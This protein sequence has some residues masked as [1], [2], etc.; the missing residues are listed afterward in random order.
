VRIR[1]PHLSA[2][3]VSVALGLGILPGSIAYAQ[4]ALPTAS[5]AQGQ[6]LLAAD[7]LIY[8]FD[9][10][11]VTAV[12]GVQIK[13]NGYDLVAQK[14][15]FNRKT[16]RLL[17]NGNV[18]LT[19]PDGTKLYADEIDV[20]DNLADGFINALRV[21][22]TD[23]TRFAAVR[24]TRENG[25]IATF[26]RGVYTACEPCLDKPEKPPT[27]QVKAETIIWNQ[28]R[29]T[30]R[31]QGARFELF[32]FSLA[33]LPS[34]EI[35]DHTVKRKS[36]FLMPTVGY[37]DRLGAS[38]SIPYFWALAPNM[39]F[40][41][42]ARPMS[43]Q[44]LFASGKFAHQL[45]SGSYTVTIAGTSQLDPNAFGAGTVN[46][47]QN[48]RFLV[49]TK[50]AFKINPRW[51][52]GWDVVAQTDKNFGY[53]YK[54]PGYDAYTRASEIYLTGL[55][56]RNYFDLRASRFEVQEDV[57]SG[58][59]EKQAT[60]LPSF[61]YRKTF[62]EAVL[63]GELTLRM[64]ARNIDRDV[65]DTAFVGLTP[66]PTFTPADNDSWRGIAGSNGRVTASADWQSTFIA[67]GGLSITPIAALRADG[68]YSDFDDPTIGNEAASRGLIAETRDTLFRGLV[69]AGLDIKY[70][71]LFTAP[72]STH[73]LEPRVQLLARN[74]VEGQERLGSANEDAQSLVF[75]A[76]NLFDR[77]K[78]SGLD[79]IEGG[80]RANVGL[81]Y[82]GTFDNGVRADASFGQSFNVAGDN[83][84]AAPDLVFAGA[85]SG[86]ETKASDYVASA[87]LAYNEFAV[88]G[89]ARFD[90]KTFELRRA[91]VQASSRFEDLSLS[92]R[93]TYIQAQPQYGFSNDRQE[94]KGA[95][96]LK[97]AE[98]WTASANAVFNIEAKK[99]SSFG[100]G[101]RYDDECFTYGMAYSESRDVV[102]NVKKRTVGFNISLRTLGEISN[103]LKLN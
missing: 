95:A 85:F 52:F 84:F 89:G 39:D 28:Q 15:K 92:A 6:M 5:T 63:G 61:D 96:S 35:A 77:D 65:S 44:G 34:F 79:R 99:T 45:N 98:N 31:F 68:V 7:S 30:I 67:P 53:T 71:I 25:N 88:S 81:R 72:G 46:A 4:S 26:E 76:S 66:L 48:S 103:D 22:T 40:T 19:Q 56:D 3:C 27:W 32:G 101:L 42:T 36:G 21:E 80:V 90:E 47:A 50:G 16:K 29:K 69:T 82:S 37:T 1:A 33:A 70:P 64:N 10:E 2:L 102:S 9:G 14:V 13:Y 87:S 62:D 23:N 100:F 97:F 55:S 20:T 24:A 60:V 73:I 11:T 59:N 57:L 74:D 8:D 91:D 83:P 49:G 58:A 17:A 78:F 51:S 41:L 18:E 54:V 86:L 12:G 94:V 75:D 43:R 93:Y 38:A